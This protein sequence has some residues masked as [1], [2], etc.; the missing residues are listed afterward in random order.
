MCLIVC[1]KNPKGY[2]LIDFNTNKVVTKR[3]VAFNETNLQ[4]F[5]GTDA[6]GMLFPIESLIG[7]EED[8]TT[9]EAPPRRFQ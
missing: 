7:C 8:K 1:S 2:R 3:D 6:E 9:S 5:K 4:H